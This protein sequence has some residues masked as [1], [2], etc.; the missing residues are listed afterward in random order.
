MGLRAQTGEENPFCYLGRVHRRRWFFQSL[1]TTDLVFLGKQGK[2]LYASNSAVVKEEDVD[3]MEIRYVFQKNKDN[4]QKI[5]YS[6]SFNIK[7]CPIRAGLRITRRAQRLKVRAH[8]PI[9]VYSSS[10]K[11][12]AQYVNDDH[13]EHILQMVAKD[14][15]NLT[16]PENI[17]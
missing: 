6:K 16:L 12:K 15:Y 1:H 9:A 11:R 2:H 4:G 14:L 13:I 8:T 5:K 3:F 7:L 10:S 17:K